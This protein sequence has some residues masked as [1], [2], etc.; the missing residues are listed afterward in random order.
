MVAGTI[1]LVQQEPYEEGWSPTCWCAN[2]SPRNKYNE[3]QPFHSFLASWRAEPN[4]IQEV[5][6]IQP[7]GNEWVS[8]LSYTSNATGVKS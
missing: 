8:F 6:A 3:K 4:N 2:M 1:F 7:T 5:S